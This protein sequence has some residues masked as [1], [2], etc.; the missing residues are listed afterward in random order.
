MLEPIGPLRRRRLARWPLRKPAEFFHLGDGWSDSQHTAP[1]ARPDA[2]V[3]P[4]RDFA[5]STWDDHGATAGVEDLAEHGAV[6]RFAR[7]PF[8]LRGSEQRFLDERWAAAPACPVGLRW[9]RSTLRGASGPAADLVD[10]RALMGR[11]AEQSEALVLRL[12]P[13]YRGRLRRG[14]TS[15][16]PVDIADRETGWRDDDTR[17]HVDASPARPLHGARL[18]RVFTNVSPDGRARR[19]RV[20]EPFPAHARRYLASLTRPLPGA[21]WLLM[22][23]GVTERCRSEY[24][25]VMLQLHD[26]A[27][28]DLAFQRTSPQA[29]LEFAPGTTWVLFSDQV[30]HAAMAGQHLLEQTFHLEVEHQRLPDTS[31]L[32]TLERLLHRQL[33]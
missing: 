6:L 17:L 24:D 7:L 18:L 31:P 29:S 13:H 5:D 22:S 23:V 8:E 10:L 21:A 19:W 3:T 14:D 33:L 32:R 1:P 28:A 16:C 25:H 15:F 30:P 20:G 27:K 2:A 11:Y 9:P 4:V 26:H 12:F